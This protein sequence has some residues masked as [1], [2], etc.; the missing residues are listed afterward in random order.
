MII[1]ERLLEDAF[2]ELENELNEEVWDE[3][4]D[5]AS[6]NAHTRQL[7]IKV[8]AMHFMLIEK[9]HRID[10]A[11]QLVKAEELWDQYKRENLGG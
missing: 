8:R 7:Y 9:K 4:K 11:R 3:C 2:W 5:I 1:P 6:T 10:E